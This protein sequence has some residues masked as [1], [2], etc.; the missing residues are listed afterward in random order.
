MN[1][2]GLMGKTVALKMAT[3]G[4][5]GV[6]RVVGVCDAPMAC[7]AIEQTGEEVWWRQDLLEPM[8]AGPRFE[9]DYQMR[10]GWCVMDRTAK[11]P[12]ATH[13]DEGLAKLVAGLLSEREAQEV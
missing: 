13:M 2:N 7:I 10:Q 5:N 11:R 3:G 4:V 8:P 9:A 6:G 12:V 1:G